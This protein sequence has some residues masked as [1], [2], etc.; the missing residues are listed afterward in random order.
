[1]VFFQRFI[2][3]LLIMGA[4]IFVGFLSYKG[5]LLYYDIY[6]GPKDDK[7]AVLIKELYGE[8]EVV[9]VSKNLIYCIGEDGTINAV[10]L[11]IFNTLTDNLDYITIPMKA[12]FTITNELYQKLYASGCEAPQ[13]IK[14]SKIDEYFS[15]ETLFIYGAI[16][17][18]DLLGIQ[19]NYYTA[20]DA[21]TFKEMFKKREAD[22]TELEDGTVISSYYEWKIKK[23]YVKK[24]TQLKDDEAIETFIKERIN[25]CNSNLNTRSKLE[26][27]ESYKR[28]DSKLIH[29]HSIYGTLEGNKFEVE[30]ESSKALLERILQNETYKAEQKNEK[31]QESVRDSL[32]YSIEILNASQITGL[33]AAYKGNFEKDGYTVAGIG[34]YQGQMMN[35]TKIIVRQEGLGKDLLPYFKGAVIEM[36]QLPEGVDIQVILGTEDRLE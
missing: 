15:D 20:A 8:V 24:L 31:D 3:S 19:I 23:S 16:L 21:K 29:T 18:E 13:I 6:G 10:V 7:A 2:K 17:L 35:Q 26:Y 5:T 33:A 22:F 27:L 25:N 14:L 12:T 11:E 32:G 36:G 30:T 34:N 9:D 1:M 28:L 4:L